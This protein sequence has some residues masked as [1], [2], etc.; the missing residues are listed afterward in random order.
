MGWWSM[1]F[2]GTNNEINATYRYFDLR[3]F[4]QAAGLVHPHLLRVPDQPPVLDEV[5]V[6]H[7]Y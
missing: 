4:P 1:T 3:G 5:G 6:M 2:G 7:P